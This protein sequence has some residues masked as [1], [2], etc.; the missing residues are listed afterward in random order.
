VAKNKQFH[1]GKYDV[2][3]LPECDSIQ[4]SEIGIIVLSKHF[5]AIN[6]HCS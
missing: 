4:S 1:D 3:Y 6:Y 2:Y 5:Y